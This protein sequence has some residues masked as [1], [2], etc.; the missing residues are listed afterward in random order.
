MAALGRPHGCALLPW[1]LLAQ[2]LAIVR[3]VSLRRGQS[4]LA[5][6]DYQLE[7]KNVLGVQY[8]GT[9]GAGDQ[10][11]PVIYDTGSFEIVLLSKLCGDICIKGKTVYDANLSSSFVASE[12]VMQVTYAS[13]SATSKKG[14]DS[15][16][17][18]G[19]DSPYT[20]KKM[21]LWQVVEHQIPVWNRAK[22]SGIIGLG[23][24]KYMPEGFRHPPAN[25]T[26]PDQ[27]LL[28]AMG[29][30]MFSICLERGLLK[31]GWMAMGPKV[32]A[33]AKHPGFTSVPV[34]GEVHWGL[35]MAEVQA[36]DL[37][38][39]NPCPTGCGAIV[40]SGTSF[41]AVP[42][43][44][45]P[46]T[47]AIEIKLKMDCSN[48]HELPVLRIQLDGAVVELPPMAYIIKIS[49]YCH[50]AFMEMDSMSQFGPVWIL[51]MP[52][53]R[54]HYTVFDRKNMQIHF[55]RST[56]ACEPILDTPGV[57]GNSSFAAVGQGLYSRR[58]FAPE[59]YEPMEADRNEEL[60]APD[61]KTFAF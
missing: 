11:L 51:G 36:E 47:D 42:P 15:V 57:A 55:A 45:K 35:R 58:V 23:H 31:P 30:D 24:P 40:D 60:P 12:D 54:Y 17:I 13:G 56:P 10:E 3:S 41:I 43:S 5:N 32:Q 44:A 19:K 46:L 53:L 59:D 50:T 6:V 25:G 48:L 29:I 21:P 33:L 14:F 22:F 7:L 34:V 4:F 9:F 38:V 37:N 20:V 28:P 18:G 8:H 61:S 49:G 26:V 39:S 16:S 2:A 27:L 1:L 52:F